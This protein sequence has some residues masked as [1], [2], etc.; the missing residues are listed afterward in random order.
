MRISGRGSADVD[1]GVGGNLWSKIY[2]WKRM[3]GGEN[4]W[5]MK[6]GWECLG[7][8]EEVRISR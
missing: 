4:V 1:E 3:F 5:E 7:E 8:E 2:M 6:S